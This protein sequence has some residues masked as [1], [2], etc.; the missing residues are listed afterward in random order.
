[1]VLF[2]SGSHKIN[3]GVAYE[4]F[5][6]EKNA[7]LGFHAFSGCDQ[8]SKFN[9]KSKAT[10]WKAFLDSIEDVFWDLGVTDDLTGLTVTSLEKYVVRLFCESGNL[11]SLTD[12]RW[13]I[14]KKQ[15]DCIEGGLKVQ[16]FMK[17]PH[18]SDMEIVSF[19]NSKVLW[20]NHTS[21]RKIGRCFDAHLDEWTS[22]FRS[23]Y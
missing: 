20:F 23:C 1:M 16:A 4:V 10:C 9:G 3:V 5:G 6:P 19:A 8:T 15:Q 11:N 22:N 7:L 12:V 2:E 18:M 17:L 14:Y 13:S 21:M